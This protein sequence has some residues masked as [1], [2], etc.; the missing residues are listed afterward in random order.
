MDSSYLARIEAS[1]RAI[2][3][4]RCD[5]FTEE[6]IASLQQAV[7]ASKIM[8]IREMLIKQAEETYNIEEELK[9]FQ[10]MLKEQLKEIGRLNEDSS[11]AF[12][13]VKENF[14]KNEQRNRE[15]NILTW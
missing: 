6:D 1:I 7:S 9:Q 3:E 10:K 2:I 15:A 14:S 8:L 4:Q 5:S 11:V 13:T 12:S